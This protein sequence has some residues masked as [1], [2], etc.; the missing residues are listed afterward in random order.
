MDGSNQTHDDTSAEVCQ[1]L[2]ALADPNR[3]R[4]FEILMQGDAC[5]GHLNEQLGLAPNLL[6]HHLSVLRKAGLVTDRR[7]AVDARWI[8]YAV[9]REALLTWYG[10]LTTFF[11]PARLNV[12]PNVCGPEYGLR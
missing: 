1:I 11:H 3:L 4:I 9:N 7:D 10:W 6:S 2:K 8:Y 12:Q 5:N